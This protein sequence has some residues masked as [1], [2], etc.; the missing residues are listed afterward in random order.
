MNNYNRFLERKSVLLG[1]IIFIIVAGTFV[2]NQRVT[3][4]LQEDGTLVL[5]VADE[6]TGVSYII[7]IDNLNNEVNGMIEYDRSS[8]N[9]IK[10]Y[11]EF[12]NQELAK[13]LQNNMDSVAS[14]PVKITF[15]RPLNQV[16]FTKFI[17]QYA[18]GVKYYTIYM[19]EPDGKIATIQG[20]PS[21]TELVPIEF[22][23]TATT[24]ISQEYNTSA[25]FL[26]WVEVEGTVEVNHISEVKADQRVFLIDVM[27]L[28][29]ESKL[30]EESLVQAGVA[31]ST[32]RELL[33]VGF[34][35]IYRAPLA[36]E[37]YHWGLMELGEQE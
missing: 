37:L 22:F 23:N 14:I 19:L 4:R 33:K 13:I 16:E 36:W 32:R 15:N 29:L 26:G 34:T 25:E 5:S 18:I 7:G 11:R 17:K 2:Y 3:A 27:Q 1:L 24:S 12:N 35:E 20:S 6:N 21:D 30:T 8:A 10:Q 31:P 28:F 9:G